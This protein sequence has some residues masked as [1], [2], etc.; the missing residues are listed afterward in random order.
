VCPGTGSYTS[1]LGEEA[2]AACGHLSGNVNR[3]A[4]S[5]LNAIPHGEDVTA[6]ACP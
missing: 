4:H 1:Q 5:L 6:F 3:I 2:F